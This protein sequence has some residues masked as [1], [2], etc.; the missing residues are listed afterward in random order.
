ME[1]KYVA[2][3]LDGC[4]AQYDGWKGLDHIGEPQPNAKDAMVLLKD[5]GF[6]IIIH[7][8]RAK[9]GHE[10]IEEYMEE[11]NLP[12]DYINH[13]P[14][15]PDTAGLDG[16]TFAHYYIDDRNPHFTNILDSAMKIQREMEK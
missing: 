16:K 12:Y 8:C 7:T 6:E 3:D 9:E 10:T 13:N 11:H 14:E 4:I 5:L 15:Q 2:I 1:N